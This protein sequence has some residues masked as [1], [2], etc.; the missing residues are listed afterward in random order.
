MQF[1]LHGNLTPAAGEA[2]MRH[3]HK[4][5]LPG[6]AELTAD[7]APGEV[8]RAAGAKQWD[9]LTSDSAIVRAPFDEAT[10]FGRSIVFLQLSGGDVEQDDAIDRLFARFERLSPGRIYTLTGSRAKVRQLPRSK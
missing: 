6:E 9:I 2:L 4:I 7:S 8:L 3:G 1:L 10:N 5:H